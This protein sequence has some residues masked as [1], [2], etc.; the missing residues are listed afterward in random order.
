MNTFCF[1]V[2]SWSDRLPTGYSP[3]LLLCH[4]LTAETEGMPPCNIC[5]ICN[6]CNMYEI[7]SRGPLADL[8]TD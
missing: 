3:M 5:N 7:A 4:S 6:I 1:F 2:N 8:L